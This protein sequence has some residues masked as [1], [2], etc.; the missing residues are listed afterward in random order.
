MPL[1]TEAEL[2]K[3]IKSRSF[4]PVYVIYGSEQMYVKEYTKKLVEAVAGKQPG[5]F[6]FHTFGGEVN[7]DTLASSIGVV[8]FMS[9]YNCVVVTDIFL[10][11][12][13]S[14]D[15][16]KLKEICKTKAEGT[17]LIISM[18]SYVPKRNAKAF[19]AI[20]KRAQKD[21]SVIKFEKPGDDK[22]E[23]H[24][25]K[26][27]NTQGKFISRLNAAHLIKLC[28]NDLNR[29]KNE[30]DKICAY[31]PG[32]EIQT[33]AID[34]LVAQT[35]EARIF[36]LSDQVLAGRGD[37]A[38]MTLDQLFNQNR[39]DEAFMTLD[40]LFNQKEE[41]IMMLY[42]LSNAFIDAYRVR[43]ADESG[44]SLQALAEDFEYGR[45][46]FALERAR[47]S[48]RNVSTEALRKCLDLLCEAD[49]KMKS[50]SVNERLLLEQ[51]I[52]QLLITAG[53]GKG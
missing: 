53:E 16:D 33:E 3:Q 9:E 10:D 42:V 49:E 48:T 12:L 7:L 30:V 15:L 37:E 24:I 44:V 27:A 36:S 38:F 43:A 8:P 26:W 51:L 25:A 47:K 39:G 52:A 5:D 17:V 23:K 18:P 14:A 32:E 31:T 40:Q 21:G 4:S 6:N 35:L 50:V 29:L 11:M 13:G 22:L 45:R 1:I 34:K 19:E 28:G 20:V 41:P 2:K 46:T